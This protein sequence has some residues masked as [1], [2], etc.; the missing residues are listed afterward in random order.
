[1]WKSLLIIFDRIM[2]AEYIP[3]EWRQSR[4]NMLF[5]GGKT[6]SVGNYRGINIASNVGK[7]FTRVITGRLEK[8]VEQRELLGDI[9]FGFRKDKRTT[10]ALFILSQIIERQKRKGKKIALAFLDIRKAYDRVD[11]D[12]LWEVLS[13]LGYGGKFLRILKNMY[14]Q[15]QARAS[16]NEIESE[17]IDLK[18]GLKQGCVMSP[19]LFALYIKDLG[20]KLVASG[21]GIQ[22]GD[23]T[24][25]GLFFAD[26]IVLTA[27]NSQDL[28]CL[29][30]IVAKGVKKRKLQFN[31]DKSEVMVSWIKPRKRAIWRLGDVRI[32]EGGVKRINIGEVEDY[33]YLG[34]WV[35]LRG[36][37][38]APHLGRLILKEK[39]VGVQ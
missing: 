6:E 10:D 39:Q 4:I 37:V 3:K 12:T 26:D 2:C 23:L 33:K 19:L 29:L 32:K 21:K 13:S 38:F 30:E 31:P 34:A 8:D 16:S 7:L 9:Q 28:H 14:S 36:P 18:V 5:K 1:M 11:R 27:Q 15:L 35:K 20:D 22:I 24:I 17:V 25:P